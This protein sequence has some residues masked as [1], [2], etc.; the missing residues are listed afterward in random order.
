MADELHARIRVREGD[1]VRTIG[2]Q[3]AMAKLFVAKALK[4]DE[5]AF[6]KLIPFIIALDNVVG[7]KTLSPGLS[8]S[9][10]AMLRR[11]AER[12]LQSLQT[13]QAP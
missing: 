8:E 2:K 4:G 6:A 5:R 10:R 13:E 12:L 9:E 1:R 7:A 11:H 3:Q